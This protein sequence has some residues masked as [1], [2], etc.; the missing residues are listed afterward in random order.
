[1]FVRLAAGAATTAAIEASVTGAG[2]HAAKRVP[3]WALEEDRPLADD[4]VLVYVARTWR[5]VI[6]GPLERRAPTAAT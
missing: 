4:D 6:V 5:G 2:T 3:R 1:M